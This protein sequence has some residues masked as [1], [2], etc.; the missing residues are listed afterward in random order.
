[1]RKLLSLALV[2]ALVLMAAAAVAET[3]VISYESRGAPKRM[4][5]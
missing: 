1:M 3:Q 4:S 2:L 5:T